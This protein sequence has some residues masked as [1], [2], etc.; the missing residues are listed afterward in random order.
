ERAPLA[1]PEQTATPG[2]LERRLEHRGWWA[3]FNEDL[4][5]AAIN[6]TAEQIVALTIVGSLLA[7]LIFSLLAGSAL[8]AVPAL[9]GG[10]FVARGLVRRRRDKQ[11]ALFEDMIA[12]HV[13][14]I[15]SAMRAGHSMIGAIAATQ[16]G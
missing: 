7:A 5:I 2:W 16:R 9:I 15:A 3:E 12:G 8:L 14:E 6:L 13:Q 11:R 1:Q 10:P 4:D